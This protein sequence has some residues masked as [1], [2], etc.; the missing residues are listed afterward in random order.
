MLSAIHMVTSTSR[1]SEHGNTFMLGHPSECEVL[2]T[3]DMRS[4][5]LFWAW[6]LD[7]GFGPLLHALGA[8]QSAIHMVTSTLRWSEHANIFIL[9][10]PSEFQVLST[11]NM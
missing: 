5:N 8:M 1:C 11:P 7:G 6:M 4:G 10:H 2:S 3:P 9:R